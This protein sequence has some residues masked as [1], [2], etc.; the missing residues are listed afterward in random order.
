MLNIPSMQVDPPRYKAQLTAKHARLT[1][2]FQ[3]ISTPDLE[4]FPSPPLHFRM[5]AEFRVWHEKAGD[6]SAEC[7][8]AM[9][10]RANPKTAIRIEEYPIAHQSISQLMPTIMTCI[11][12]S[13]EL[14]TRL[15]QIEYLCTQNSEVI[16]TMI[17]HRPLEAQWME[18]AEQLAK[19]LNCKIIGR[20]RKQRVVLDDDVITETLSVGSKKYQFL[21]GENTFTQP[22]AAINQQMISWL[23]EYLDAQIDLEEHAAHES[24]LE[25]YC[26]IGNF[27]IPLARHFRNVLATEISKPSTK[28]AIK[29]CELNKTNNIQFVRLSGEE[30]CQAL[31]GVRAFRRLAHLDLDHYRFTTVLVDPPRAG[32]DDDTL[33]FIKRFDRILYIS[34]NPETLH[35]NL[36]YLS[37]THDIVRMALFDQFPYTDH[38]EAGA[39]LEKTH[40]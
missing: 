16:V 39:I 28:L 40:A 20:S 19:Q 15:F 23:D 8:H 25:M 24:L 18:E 11:N 17:Y 3:N 32:L 33:K 35:A 37:Q 2:L 10:E 6:S 13:M 34:C 14:K 21:M 29:N 30:T 38:C 9:F 22:N 36:D 31:D 4:V 26:G 27:T 5:R 7:F 12:Q 1:H